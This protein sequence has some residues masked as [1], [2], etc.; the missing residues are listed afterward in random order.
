MRRTG[1]FK[2]DHDV[3]A[4]LRGEARALRAKTASQPTFPGLGELAPPAACQAKPITGSCK[5]AFEA[6]WFDAK[7]GACKPFLWGGL[8]RTAAVR[9]A[10]RLP[11]RLPARLR[12]AD[13]SEARGR[14]SSSSR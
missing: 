2:F 1:D 10:E 5:G 8:R 11:A 3:D 13:R 7:A 9:Y 4:P 6:Y 12:A 14:A